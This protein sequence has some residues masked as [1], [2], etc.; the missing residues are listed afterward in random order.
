MG[1][2]NFFKK[3]YNFYNNKNKNRGNLLFVDR[4]RIDTIFQFSILSLALSNKYNLNTVILTDQKK[5]SLIRKTY[6]K[7][8]YLNLIDGY[9]LKRIIFSPF[10]LSKSL[11]YVFY[12]IL[13]TYFLGFDWFINNFKINNIYIGDLIYDANIRYNHRFIKPKIDY[14]F[15]KLLFSSICRFFI[16]KSYLSNLNI[17]KIVVGTE[18][19][20]RNNGLALRISSELNIKNYTYFRFGKNGLS[21]LSYKKKYYLRGIDSILKKDFL[22]IS[23]NIPFKKID[24]FYNDRKKFNT[25]NWYTLNDFKI[26]NFSKNED[27]KF[28][29]LLSNNKKHKILFACHAFADAP[30]AAGQF[31]FNDYY[32]QFVETLSF[33]ERD[34]QNFWIFRAHPNSRILNEQCIFK[35]NF[36]GLKNKNILLCPPNVP[37]QKLINICDVIVTGRGT[38]G[39]EAAALGKKVLIAGSAPYSDLEIAI[40]PK[41]KKDY[42]NF[43]KRIQIIKNTKSKSEISKIAKQLIYIY[44][45]SLNVKTIKLNQ[46]SK[47]GSYINFLKKIYSKNID[48]NQIFNIYNLLLSKDIKQSTVYNK[49]KNIV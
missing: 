25:S 3:R 27:K 13:K 9:S 7:L 17:K 2:K 47:D 42:F 11:F 20:P 31:I 33:A 26:A 36:E 10:I 29:N 19:G 44:E 23:K 37:I 39:M 48:I 49:L 18:T 21:V 4:E 40:K 5:N 14:Y 22:K 35:K 15:F 46:L 16:I 24:K 28:L 8:G 41:S 43:L 6:K 1:I 12:S 30:H 32:E 45:N 34:D 38:I